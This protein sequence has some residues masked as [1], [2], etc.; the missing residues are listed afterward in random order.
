MRLW[1]LDAQFVRFCSNHGIFWGLSRLLSHLE[2]SHSIGG[3]AFKRGEGLQTVDIEDL[4]PLRLPKT[5]F[6]SRYYLSYIENVEH[7][8]Q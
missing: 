2:A 7:H 6:F 8:P 4:A 1:I 3:F 5:L